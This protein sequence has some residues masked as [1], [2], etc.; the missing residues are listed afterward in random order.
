MAYD[1]GVRDL[2]IVNVGD[3]S[4]QEFPCHIP[5]SSI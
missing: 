5:R 1:F 4:T 3:I 2:W